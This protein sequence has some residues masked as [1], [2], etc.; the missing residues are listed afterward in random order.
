M[1]ITSPVSISL[2]STYVST[3]S[4]IPV[5]S[6]PTMRTGIGAAPVRSAARSRISTRATSS[7]F[8]R[9]SYRR[10]SDRTIPSICPTSAVVAGS[11]FRNT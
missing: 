2:V 6:L 3:L 8:S 1:K 7:C 10:C 4:A 5:G 11:T 9:V